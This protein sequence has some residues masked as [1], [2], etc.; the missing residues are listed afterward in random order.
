MKIILQITIILLVLLL[1]SN[2][3]CAYEKHEPIKL[4]DIHATAEDPYIIEGYEITNPTGDCLIIMNSEHIII[5]QNYFHDC[6]TDENFQKQ[7]D[8]YKEGYASLIG[9]SSNIV[10]ENNELDNNFRGFMAYN[11]PNLKA[12]N[13]K[14][15]NT[16]QYSPLWCERCSDSEFSFNY[17]SDNGDPTHFWVPSDRSIGIW[18]KRSDNVEIHDNTGIKRK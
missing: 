17:L 9:N 13:N 10:F 16:I 15:I 11:T 1:F 6:G 7:T 4:K 5:R 18:I 2:T 14:I 8:H 3:V 12:K